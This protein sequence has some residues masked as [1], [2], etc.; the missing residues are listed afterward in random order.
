MST[1]TRHRRVETIHPSLPGISPVAPLNKSGAKMRDSQQSLD[2]KVVL[3]QPSSDS[4]GMKIKVKP[5]EFN[6]ILGKRIPILFPQQIAKNRFEIVFI[7]IFQD[8]DRSWGKHRPQLTKRQGGVG[9]MMECTDHGGAVEKSSHE[10]QP[11]CIRRHVHVWIGS[12]QS[13]LCL[14]KVGWLNSPPGPLVYNLYN[15]G[16]CVRHLRPVPVINR[17][18]EVAIVLMR[19]PQ[20]HPRRRGN[21]HPRMLS[22]N[23]RPCSHIW[24]G[25]LFSYR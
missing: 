9:H 25:C 21:P 5:G 10:R 12:A 1:G 11:V 16:Y 18:L 22:G 13:L 24:A 6:Y 14:L 7:G 19:S 8:E 17:H 20:L 23:R 2:G 15:A 3:T 4:F